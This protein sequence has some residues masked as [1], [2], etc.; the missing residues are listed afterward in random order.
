M[1]HALRLARRGLYTT[2]PNPRVGCVVVAGG[3]I[4]GEGWHERAGAPHAEVHALRA[5]AVRCRGASV[6]VTLE[7]CCHHGRTPP[8]TDLLVQAQVERVVV[9]MEDP[10]PQVSG[11]G[12]AALRAA[13]VTV[14]TGLLREQAESLNP[15]FVSRMRRRRPFVRVKLAASLDGRTAMRSGASKWITGEAARADVQRWRARSSAI[16]CGV[17]TVLADDPELTVRDLD[18]GRQP[19][20]IVVDTDLRTPST[21]KLLRQDGA[22][23]IVCA[24]NDGERARRLQRAGAEV[25]RLAGENGSVHLHALMQHLA[26]QEINEVLVESGATLCGGLMQAALVDELVVY[27]APTLMGAEARGMFRLPGLEDMQDRIDLEIKDVRAVGRDWR[28][29]AKLGREA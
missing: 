15:G 13:G 27:V 19:V 28:F 9:A 24:C 6:F 17:G 21:A 5:A 26:A 20:R 14:E 29:I 23:V 2:D 7:P 4:V 18:I 10:N 3:E 16:L 22:A 8:C 25:I 1:A 12:L 11:N